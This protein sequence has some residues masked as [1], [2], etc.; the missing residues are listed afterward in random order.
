MSFTERLL[1]RS[2]VPPLPRQ[3]PLPTSVYRLPGSGQVSWSAPPHGSTQM[4]CASESAPAIVFF[5]VFVSAVHG[6]PSSEAGDVSMPG[7]KTVHEPSW[8]CW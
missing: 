7:P 4:Y 6:F 5:S 2:L 1:T 8:P 3:P